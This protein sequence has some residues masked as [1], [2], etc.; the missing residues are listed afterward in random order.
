MNILYGFAFLLIIYYIF[1]WQKITNE[2]KNKFQ[3]Q[4]NDINNTQNIIKKQIEGD[5]RLIEGFSNNNKINFNNIP[6]DI[7]EQRNNCNSMF[8]S[9]YYSGIYNNEINDELF[10]YSS[11][12]KN[13]N[14]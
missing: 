14:L 6:V 5:N 10:N 9:S 1:Q 12:K 2:L 11:M 4:H 7:N 8:L 3:K 13:I